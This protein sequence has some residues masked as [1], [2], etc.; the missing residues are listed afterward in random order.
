[1]AETK[2]DQTNQTFGVDLGMGWGLIH[3]LEI[4]GL[5]GLF[6]L[7]RGLGGILLVVI[8][9]LVRFSSAVC[10][11]GWLAGLLAGFLAGWTAACR[12]AGWLATGGI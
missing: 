11:A 5:F 7:C 9:I 3:F 10:L 2:K 8:G 4:F 6:G 1:M 12:L